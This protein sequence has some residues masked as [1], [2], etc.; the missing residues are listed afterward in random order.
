MHPI[1]LSLN[2]VPLA[3][4]FSFFFN[5]CTYVDI[6]VVNFIN[7]LTDSRLQ[8]MTFHSTHKHD[9]TVAT[10]FKVTLLMTQ[11]IYFLWI[12]RHYHSVSP[13]GNFNITTHSE[14]VLLSKTLYLFAMQGLV[15]LL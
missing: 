5:L 8:S 9:L 3:Y 6:K 14:L 7:G 13:L 10:I 15:K 4:S 11:S 12:S 1:V 2:V